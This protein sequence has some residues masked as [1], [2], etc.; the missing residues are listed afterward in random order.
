MIEKLWVWITT[1]K[2]NDNILNG[3]YLED[4]LENLN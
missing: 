1:N 4:L 2:N 3:Q